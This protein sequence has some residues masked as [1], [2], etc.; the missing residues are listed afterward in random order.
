[1]SAELNFEE[2]IRAKDLQISELL[3]EIQLLKDNNAQS[4]VDTLVDLEILI[5]ENSEPI[6]L[7]M[8]DD[9]SDDNEPDIES[10]QPDIMGLLNMIM[11]G[12]GNET[13]SANPFLGMMQQMM[14]GLP[15]E[16]I[17]ETAPIAETDPI[18]ETAPIAETN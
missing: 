9:E 10:G 7:K 2:I 15:A 6:T 11:G 18:A 1:M 8:T 12:M 17:A 5:D 16:P 3:A 14:G 13:N 4:I